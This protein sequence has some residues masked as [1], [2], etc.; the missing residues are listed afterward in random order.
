M[1]VVRFDSDHA[2]GLLMRHGA[3][4]VAPGGAAGARLSAA[5]HRHTGASSV[6]QTQGRP[7]SQSGADTAG[8]RRMALQAAG[9]DYPLWKQILDPSGYLTRN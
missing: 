9:A 4:A 6:A 7:H 8:R 1:L 5:K 3:R 2:R